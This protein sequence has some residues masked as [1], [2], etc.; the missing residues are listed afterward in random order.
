MKPRTPSE[1]SV[2]AALCAVVMAN[3]LA[4]GGVLPLLPVIGEQVDAGPFELGLLYAMF[5]IALFVTV[6]PLGTLSDA[7]GR[8]LVITLGTAL[9]AA[10]SLGFALSSEYWEFAFFRLLQG[11]SDAAVWVSALPMVAE[12]GDEK[13]LGRRSGWLMMFFGT[14]IIIGPLLGG[15]GSLVITYGAVSAATL[16]VFACVAFV[17]RGYREPCRETGNV[18]RGILQ[19]FKN[20]KVMIA[21]LTIL[22]YGYVFGA[23]EPTLPPFFYGVLT[24][25]LIGVYLMVLNAVFT[26]AQPFVGRLADRFGE[27]PLIYGSVIAFV[28]LM[29]LVA[30]TNEPLVWLALMPLLGVAM[31]ASATPSMSMLNR[32]ITDEKRGLASSMYNLLFAIGSLS[33]PIAV[34][35]VVEG[36]GYLAGMFSIS[37]VAVLVIAVMWNRERA[38]KK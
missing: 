13:T 25:A 6:I 34:G 15:T 35:A 4:W 16:A 32:S 38:L 2:M 8:R 26:F 20:P 30:V 29:P 19:L 18:L 17:F 27:M 37:A 31:A 1:L 36:A 21:G 7:R 22:I 11:V 12:F 24:V 33:G 3:A 23:I 9:L 14:G 5:P 28:V 10:S